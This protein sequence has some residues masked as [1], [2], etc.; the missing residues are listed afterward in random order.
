MLLQQTRGFQ[1]SHSGIASSRRVDGDALQSLG[2]MP[3]WIEGVF[4]V[5]ISAELLNCAV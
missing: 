5:V 3:W 2:V 1:A 4:T